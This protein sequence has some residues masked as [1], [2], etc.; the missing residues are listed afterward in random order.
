M[1][2]CAYYGDVSAVRSLLILG[3]SLKELGANLVWGKPAFTDT[4]DS[5]RFLLDH[6]ADVNDQAGESRETPLHAALCHTDRTLY[7]PVLKV[8]LA[9]GADPNLHAADGI[10]TEGFMRDA[11]TK[12]ETPLHR[13]AAFGNE[14]TVKMLMG[15]GAQREVRDAHYDT[16]LSWASWYLRP[17]SILRKLCFGDYRVNPN[18]KTMRENLIGFPHETQ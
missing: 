11:R 4:G 2:T 1:Q 3:A 16:P 15:A 8:L 10:E 6:G 18:R 7:D 9:R 17:A 12:G 13:A 14:T 5:A